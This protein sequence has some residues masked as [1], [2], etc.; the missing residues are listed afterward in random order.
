M[1]YFPRNRKNIKEV[2]LEQFSCIELYAAAAGVGAIRLNRPAVLNA[3]NLQT[4][5]ELV[6]AFELYDASDDVRCIVIHGNKKAFAAGADITE[7]QGAT[8]V[9]MLERDQFARW[10]RIKQTKKP[11]IAA[12]SGFALGGGCELTM[13]CDMIVASDTAQFGQP[14]INIGVMPGAGGTQR[15]TRA[16]GKALAMEM[17]LTGRMISA[18]QALAAGLVNRVVPVEFYLEEAIALAEEIAQ[19]APVAVKLAKESVLKSFST[20]LESGLEFERKNFYMLFATE[21]QKEGMTAFVEKRKADWK[22]R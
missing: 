11:I 1:P 22:G 16:V 14:E 21:D 9:T 15:L 17:V 8:A 7:M 5:I 20:S 12:V 3:L 4:M 18:K 6:A 10:E 19:K 13:L 2:D